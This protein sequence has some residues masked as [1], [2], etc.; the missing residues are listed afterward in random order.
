MTAVRNYL[1]VKLQN[2]QAAD[3]LVEETERAIQKRLYAPESFQIYPSKRKRI[4][5]YYRIG[6]KNYS[7]FYVVI[8]GVM[9]VRRFLY[10]RRNLQD[11]L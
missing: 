1:T 11:L 8:D 7:V 3:H 9:E 10:S 5:P 2:P 6:V 4:Y